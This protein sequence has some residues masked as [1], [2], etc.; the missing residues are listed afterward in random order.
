M[1]NEE[2][3]LFEIESVGV[4]NK[5][6]YFVVQSVLVFLACFASSKPLVLRQARFVELRDKSFEF[7]V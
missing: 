7:G 4:S 3:T 1:T 5:A 6:R 2:Q